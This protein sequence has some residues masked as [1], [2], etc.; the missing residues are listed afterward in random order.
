G[1][2]GGSP[3]PLNETCATA[4]PITGTS[5]VITGTT[6]LA[7][8]DLRYQS[9][10]GCSGGPDRSSSGPE[11]VYAV[12]VPGFSRLATSLRSSLP[13][14]GLNWDSIFNVIVGDVSAC[15]TAL[16]DGGF[17]QQ[18]CATGVDDP[19]DPTP[20][21]TYVNNTSTPQNAFLVVDGFS[22][23]QSGPFTLTTEVTPLA[24]GDLCENAVAVSLPATRTGDS[25]SGY[26]GNYLGGGGCSLGTSSLDRVYRV[27]VP[28]NTRLTATVTTVTPGDGGVTFSP[29]VNLVRGACTPSLTC[30]GGASSSVTATATF[31]N[32]GPAA[33]FFV[34]VDTTTTSPVGT[35]DLSVSA[36]P[37]SLTAGDVC[38][39]TSPA[40]TTSRTFPSETFA[41]FQNQYVAQGQT[42]CAYLPGLDRAYAV[43]VPAGHILTAVATPTSAGVLPDGG[44]LSLAATNLSLQVLSAA[45]ECA[46]GPCLSSANASGAGAQTVIRSNASGTTPEDLVLVV[47]SNLAAQAGTYSLAVT[48]S[49]PPAGDFCGSP[50]PLPLGTPTPR[51][52]AGFTD[53][54]RGFVPGCSFSSGRDV[55]YSVTLQP[56]QRLTVAVTPTGT[57]TALSLVAS[58]AAC[59]V[60]CLATSDAFGVGTTDTLVYDNPSAT[61]Q[62]LLLIVDSGSTSSPA[63]FTITA[64]A[65]A[66]PSSLTPGETC[67]SPAALTP[68]TTIIG[69]LSGLSNDLALRETNACLSRSLS[70]GPD[71]VYSL[72]VP[73]G[74][75][76]TARLTPTFDVTLNAVI[77]GSTSCGTLGPTGQTQGITCVAGSD[78]LNS[79]LNPG[80]ELV[81]FANATGAMQSVLLLVDSASPSAGRFDLTTT[82]SAFLPGDVCSDS[83]P[84]ITASRSSSETLAGFSN[85]YGRSTPTCA[86]AF[87]EDRVYRVTIPPSSRLTAATSSTADLRLSVVEGPASNCRPLTACL[88]SVNS[89][90][91]SC[92]GWCVEEFSFDNA[93]STA[94]DV[95]LVVDRSDSSGDPAFQLAID[96]APLPVTP[97]YVK[98]TTPQACD[99]LTGAAT[100]LPQVLQDD[101][102]TPFASLP[103]PFTFYGSPV[104]TYSVSS[105]GLVGFDTATTG[106]VEAFVVRSGMPS[107]SAPNNLA[108][109]F[110]DNLTNVPGLSTARAQVFGSPGSR[111]FVV[112][113]ANFGL[114]TPTA[115]F[116]GPERLT[117]Q[118]KVYEG[119][120]VVE[121]HYCALNA[122]GG[123]ASRVTGQLATVGLEGAAGLSA[124]VHSVQTSS[125]VNTSTALRFTP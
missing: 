101:G 37:L 36:T 7:T 17:G 87:R 89:F 15:G 31:D 57:D 110:W 34:V 99:A 20:T 91:G 52:L 4:T 23:T 29:T 95:F 18:T 28:A 125:A 120:N 107:I 55:V 68:N 11:L 70:S 12:S 30:V 100:P 56:M 43:T 24:P 115:P 58:A 6:A 27:P 90:V 35:F 54:F 67:A 61:A 103:F 5:A 94:R 75:R 114:S 40:T 98:M 121:L 32:V 92:G 59:S 116:V 64:T 42:R 41:G 62:S 26:T 77:G 1:T 2:A 108:A 65:T 3:S 112:E 14:G 88:A 44:M 22:A 60:S 118:L 39:N 74:Q 38:Q 113:W 47:D 109:V 81:T 80:V 73:D 85:D 93:G 84:A 51:D 82:V 69:S 102:S 19:D 96:F 104:T 33:D 122:N 105:N 76:L 79:P 124:V 123:S 119:T 21:Q 13:D 53:D 78:E 106:A 46:S 9:A 111:R 49:T 8:N 10:S 117:F 48:F 83:L 71:G 25:L 63:S 97:R 50:L 16:V 45:T 86:L 66:T 72:P